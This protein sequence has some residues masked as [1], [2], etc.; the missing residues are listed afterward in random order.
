VPRITPRSED[1]LILA[2]QRKGLRVLARKVKSGEPLS[3]RERVLAAATI[4]AW[5]D[6]CMNWQPPKRKPGQEA[7]VDPANVAFRFAFLI[8]G[9]NSGENALTHNAA[10]EKVAEEFDL[11]SINSVKKILKTH[12][13]FAEMMVG[14]HVKPTRR[15][16]QKSQDT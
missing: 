5:A 6:Q 8:H 13:H 12:G 1:E 9:D 15:M 14:G 3:D 16:R 2:K 11:K 10:Y 7:R 4:K